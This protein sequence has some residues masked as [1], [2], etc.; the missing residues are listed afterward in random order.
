MT[1]GFTVADVGPIAAVLTGVAAV[2]AVARATVEYRRQGAQKR[3]ELFADIRKRLKAEPRFARLTELLV[4]DDPDLETVPFI[5]KWDFLGLIEEV[6]LL[7]NSGLIREEVSHHMFSYYA[8]KCDESTH[9][10]RGPKPID[11]THPT[12]AVFND[13]ARRMRDLSTRLV[14]D[15]ATFRF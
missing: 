9:F 2:V 3:A 7:T 11:R 5:D 1:L 4:V 13:Y 12:W 15:R 8:L 10:W 6:G 14:Y